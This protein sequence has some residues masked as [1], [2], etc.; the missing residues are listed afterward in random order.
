[1]NF[2]VTL[3]SVIFFSV[4]SALFSLI[5]YFGDW[6][7]L[8]V[9]SSFGL[10]LGLMAAPEIEPKKFKHGWLLQI[11][12]GTIAGIVFGFF[13]QLSS[14][15]ISICSI[16]GGLIGWLAPLWVKHASIP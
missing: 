3:Y 11:S 14:E 12:S 15:S 4:I 7:R 10:F 2:K 13:L 6:Q 5:F 16:I 9:A 1:M 8:L